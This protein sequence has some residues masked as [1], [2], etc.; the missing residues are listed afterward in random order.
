MTKLIID[1]N[2]CVTLTPEQA[3]ALKYSEN[4]IIIMLYTKTGAGHPK[5]ERVS[6]SG[7]NFL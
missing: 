6:G 4:E 7:D 1:N 5:G 3:K 2:N